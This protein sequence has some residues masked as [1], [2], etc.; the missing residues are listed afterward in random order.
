MLLSFDPVLVVRLVC[1]P[2]PLRGIFLAK[3]LLCETRVP[4]LV[5]RCRRAAAGVRARSWARRDR[6]LHFFFAWH[7]V[8][9]SHDGHARELMLS[10]RLLRSTDDGT[11]RDVSGARKLVAEPSGLS[12]EKGRRACLQLSVPDSRSGL[13]V[14]GILARGRILHRNVRRR[15]GPHSTAFAGG[16]TE[17]GVVGIEWQG[18][19]ESDYGGDETGKHVG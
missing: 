17:E 13:F 2:A 7:C 9:R 4:A 6:N 1:V 19:I 10:P 11:L 5:A 18:Y 8:Q 3:I 16:T 12:G 15:C 14:R